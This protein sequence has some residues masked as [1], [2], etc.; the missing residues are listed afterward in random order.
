MAETKKPAAK[1]AAAKKP[2]AKKAAT[3]KKSSVAKKA[4]AK[5]VEEPVAPQHI[6]IVAADPWLEPFE[7]AIRGRHDHALWMMDHLTNG[8]KISLSDFATGYLY[9]GLHRNEKGEWIFRE[10]A[11]NATEIHLI[12]DFNGWKETAKYKLKRSKNGQD[13][14]DKAP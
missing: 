14:E 11:P 3:T 4:P 8:G 10:W 13:W 9:Y 7:G 6:G 2:A 5:K 12:G 1:K